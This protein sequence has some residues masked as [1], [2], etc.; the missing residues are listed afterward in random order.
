MVLIVF[1]DAS[2]YRIFDTICN[3]VVRLESHGGLLLGW[4]GFLTGTVTGDM[5][6]CFEGIVKHFRTL[7]SG[8]KFC[9]TRNSSWAIMMCMKPIKRSRGEAKT[10]GVR[11]PD[12]M[13]DGLLKIGK[14][15][16]SGVSRL[17]RMAVLKVYLGEMGPHDN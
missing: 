12:W 13:I 9:L 10:I 4:H 2:R 16:Q 11:M 7:C 1:S 5:V 6:A 17:V 15:E 8:V 3:Y 14:R